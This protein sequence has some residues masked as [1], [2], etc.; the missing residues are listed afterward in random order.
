MTLSWKEKIMVCF[1]LFFSASVSRTQH[2]PDIWKILKTVPTIE[3]GK[4]EVEGERKGQRG[5]EKI[6][7][8][9]I[10]YFIID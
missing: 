5:R 9:F 10:V 7:K 6:Q 2:T 1:V 3:G 8:I 4:A